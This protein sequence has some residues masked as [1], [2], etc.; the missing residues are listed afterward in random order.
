MENGRNKIL[1]I[2]YPLDWNFMFVF[3]KILKYLEKNG[4]KNKILTVYWQSMWWKVAL[5]LTY[6]LLKRWFKV[7]KII[8]NS[9]VIDK[10][11]VVLPLWIPSS[12]LAKLYEILR[13]I[14]SKNLIWILSAKPDDPDLE[15]DRKELIKLVDNLKAYNVKYKQLKTRIDFIKSKFNKKVEKLIKEHNIPIF[16]IRSKPSK[17]NLDN[18]WMIKHSFLEKLL[19]MFPGQIKYIDVPSWHCQVPE[20]NKLYAKALSKLLTEKQ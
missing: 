10:Q 16:V 5:Y 8:L 19:K 4:F 6:F 2:N 15:I 1:E 18:D 13:K 7:E 14:P 9:S 17:K 11:T 3:K 12:I 20:K